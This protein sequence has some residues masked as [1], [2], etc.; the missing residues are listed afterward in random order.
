MN[1]Q[2][3]IKLEDN[4][5]SFFFSAISKLLD[6]TDQENNPGVIRHG[7]ERTNFGENVENAKV[8]VMD[9]LQ[10]VI[11]KVYLKLV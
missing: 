7:A 9:V 5:E 10:L 8:I 11:V 6:I 3:K 2:L 1:C 4:K